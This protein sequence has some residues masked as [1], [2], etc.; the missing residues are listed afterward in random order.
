MMSKT[1]YDEDN[2]SVTSSGTSSKSPTGG[3]WESEQ[4]DPRR[5]VGARE[6]RRVAVSFWSMVFVLICVATALCTATYIVFHMEEEEE[7]RMTVCTLECKRTCIVIS[8]ALI[9]LARE[10]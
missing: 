6:Q 8:I 3:R 10:V 9:M 5:T 4:D 7:F 1:N 2:F